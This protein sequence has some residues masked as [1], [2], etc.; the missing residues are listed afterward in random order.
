MYSN[1][2]YSANYRPTFAYT[3]DVIGY[4]LKL[5]KPYPRWQYFFIITDPNSVILW[6]YGIV[7]MICTAALLYIIS[8]FEETKLDVINSFLI[9]CG[10][11]MAIAVPIYDH[12]KKWLTRLFT[13]YAVITLFFLISIYNAEFFNILMKP[14][15]SPRIGA[16]LELFNLKFDLVTTPPFTVSRPPTLIEIRPI[17][18]RIRSQ[19]SLYL[20][21]NVTVETDAQDC[22]RRVTSERNV[23]LIVSKMHFMSTHWV[24]EMYC[25]PDSEMIS[26]RPISMFIRNNVSDALAFDAIIQRVFESGIIEYWRSNV[27]Q[28]SSKY[29]TSDITSLTLEHMSGAF[30]MLFIGCFVATMVFVL[31]LFIFKRSNSTKLTRK[32][33]R[34]WIIVSKGIDG[35][36]HLLK[37]NSR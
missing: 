4:C 26:I 33:R 3:R 17:I 21:S 5:P 9:M 30:V 12:A 22:Y 7:A 10:A 19:E 16:A 6:L 15:Y 25:L 29:E 28:Q 20:Q 35:E 14:K 24:H 32:Q 8:G 23:A 34:F 18:A 11:I 36:R 2:N 1:L 37:M 31:E 27:V 13:I